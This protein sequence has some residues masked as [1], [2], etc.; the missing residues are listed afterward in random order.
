MASG[1][2]SFEF[3]N[4]GELCDGVVRLRLV[5]TQPADPA[6]GWA[7]QFVFH[8]HNEESGDRA[9][10][11]NLRIGNTER[12]LLYGGH[13]G[14]GVRP[15]YG[16]QRFAARAVRLVVRLAI[17]H[18]LCEVRITCNPENIASRRTCVAA[19]AEFIEVVER[20]PGSDMYAEGE[21]RKCRYRLILTA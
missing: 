4:P 3:L 15:E 16:G 21:L 13:I 11:I 1:E 7:P 14:Y 10:E 20:P 19:G 8:I 2:P 17:R 5:E 12:M 6:R 18:G 9:G